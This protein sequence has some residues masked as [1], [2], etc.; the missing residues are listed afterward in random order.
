VST[1]GEEGE[2]RVSKVVWY[3]ALYTHS[4][5]VFVFLV[6]PSHPCSAG[7]VVH[8]IE[9]SD[10]EVPVNDLVSVVSCMDVTCLHIISSG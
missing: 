4:L 7:E 3:R 9:T 8:G 5:F 2:P 10:L 6:L 1:G